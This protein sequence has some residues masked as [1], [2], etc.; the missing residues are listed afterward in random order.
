MDP[1]KPYTPTR[2]TAPPKL[3][4]SDAEAVALKAIVW[5][6]GDDEMLSRFVAL[7]GCGSNELRDRITQPAFLGG[8]LDFL[9]GDEA[10]VVAF[11][12][13]ADFPPE[14]PLLARALL[15]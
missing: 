9:L 14:V 4:V 3:T 11:A 1:F 15:P 12:A 13:H 10:S 8:V 2:H 6:I 7:T 5:I